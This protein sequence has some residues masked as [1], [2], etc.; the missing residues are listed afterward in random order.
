MARVGLSRLFHSA[1]TWGQQSSVSVWDHA[2]FDDFAEER[3]AVTSRAFN[4]T[5]PGVLAAPLLV[6]VPV[7]I[8]HIKCFLHLLPDRWLPAL[9]L[10]ANSIQNQLSFVP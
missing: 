2:A 6:E 5:F 9:C 8:W 10:I 3:N 4:V 1:T 7:L